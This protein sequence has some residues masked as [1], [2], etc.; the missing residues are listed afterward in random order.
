MLTINAMDAFHALADPTRRRI[1]ERL[2]A[3]ERTAGEIAESFSISG[4]AISQHLKVL[5]TSGLVSVRAEA[6]RRI[7][8]L[9]APAL[10]AVDAWLASVRSYWSPRLDELER[11]LRDERDQ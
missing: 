2:A 11:K 9:E 10:A 5:R 8:R 3:G 1:I 6:Q 7:Y 4:P